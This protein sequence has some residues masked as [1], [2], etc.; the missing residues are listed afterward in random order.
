MKK[1][2]TLITLV[3][4]LALLAGV[5]LGMNVSAETAEYT[6]Q[7]DELESTINSLPD[8][9]GGGT[10]VETCTVELVQ[11]SPD[12]FDGD[13]GAYYVDANGNQQFT[14]SYGEIIVRKNSIMFVK[15]CNEVRWV[16][17]EL[18]SLVLDQGY[19][20]DYSGYGVYFIN[21]SLKINVE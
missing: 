6:A 3:L 15:A 18:A 17:N 9:G 21:Q 16:N 5:V 7:L 14:N 12:A 1:Q 20:S 19:T 10:S 8:A 11:H 13:H 4:S 2:F